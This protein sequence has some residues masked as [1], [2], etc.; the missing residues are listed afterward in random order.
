MTDPSFTC[1]I[2]K[3]GDGLLEGMGFVLTSTIQGAK[4]LVV[5]I[6]GKPSPRHESDEE[7]QLV[8]RMERGELVDGKDSHTI[9][10][11]D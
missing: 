11:M 4:H 3:V 5:A 7:W 2:S 9:L 8:H 6:K 1:T 10:I